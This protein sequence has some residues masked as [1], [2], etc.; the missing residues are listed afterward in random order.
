ME[1][2]SVSVDQ[3]WNVL[4]MQAEVTSQKETRAK[5][6]GKSFEEVLDSEKMFSRGAPL[7]RFN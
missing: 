1:V 2:L 6:V 3:Q 5:V 7:P 4:S